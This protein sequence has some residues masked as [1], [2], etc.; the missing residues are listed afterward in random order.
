MKYALIKSINVENIIVAQSDFIETIRSEWDHI[1]QLD[2]DSPVG[3]GWTYDGSKFIKP[4]VP[5]VP[6]FEP[7]PT[8]IITRLAFL[9]RFTDAEAIAIDLASIGDTVEAAALRRCLNVLNAA[10]FID[11]KDPKT[12]AC[13]QVIESTGILSEGRSTVILDTPAEQS[14]I[15]L[16]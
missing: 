9:S 1:I 4:E 7:E 13:M 6:V 2:E 8:Y 5:E 15:P 14:E 3:V 12:A 10:N 16:I 11:L